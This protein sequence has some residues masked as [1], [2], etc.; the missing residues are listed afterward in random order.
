MRKEVFQSGVKR[1][2][3]R[4]R[5]LWGKAFFNQN[6]PRRRGRAVGDNRELGGVRPEHRR[7][8]HRRLRHRPEQDCGDSAGLLHRPAEAAAASTGRAE[9]TGRA[10]Y[11]GSARTC[12]RDCARG[13]V[14]DPAAE[15]G[16]GAGAEPCDV[17][18]LLGARG[19][20][21]G[22][23]RA[24][25]QPDTAGWGAAG[26]DDARHDHAALYTRRETRGC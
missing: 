17:G 7:L 3:T 25:L 23:L 14:G 1:L 11:D 16:C 5:N 15:A 22:C 12:R 9:A 18:G 2:N 4:N 19:A 10:A 20:V 21:G 6:K 13:A 26:V 24:R 8:G